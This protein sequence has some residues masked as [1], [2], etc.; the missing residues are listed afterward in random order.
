MIVKNVTVNQQFPIVT[1][2]HTGWAIP[3][4]QLFKLVP[5]FPDNATIRMGTYTVTQNP[6]QAQSCFDISINPSNLLLA[7]TWPKFYYGWTQKIVANINA[8]CSGNWAIFISPADPDPD[9]FQN[10]I[11][12]FGAYHISEIPL[13]GTWQIFIE[14]N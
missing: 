4:Y 10:A 2:W 11:R 3:K 5:S 13:G 7:P 8:K 12:E 1:Y 14:V 6:Q 9:V